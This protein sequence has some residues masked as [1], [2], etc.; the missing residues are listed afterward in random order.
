MQG[1][2]YAYDL[3]LSFMWLLNSLMTYENMGSNLVI[4]VLTINYLY[5]DENPKEFVGATLYCFSV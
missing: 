4:D 3:G 5:G 2:Q 1:G